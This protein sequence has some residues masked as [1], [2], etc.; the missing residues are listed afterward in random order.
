MD[1]H[2]LAVFGEALGQPEQRRFD[3]AAPGEDILAASA[4]NLYAGVATTDLDGFE[5]RYALNSRL[6]LSSR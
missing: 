3:P 4:N 1:A 2:A 6:A 5:E